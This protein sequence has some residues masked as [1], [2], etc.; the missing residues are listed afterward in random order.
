MIRSL[1]LY[2]FFIVFLGFAINCNSRDRS[3]YEVNLPSMVCMG[4]DSNTFI[5]ILPDDSM[6]LKS[7]L[8]TGLVFIPTYVNITYQ[9]QIAFNYV[10]SEWAKYINSPI[11]IRVFVDKG[12]MGSNVLASAGP[13]AYYYNFEWAKSNTL[14][15]VA[16]MEKIVGEEINGE[17]NFDIEITI[18][19]DES[20]WYFGTDGNTPP[21][22]YDFVTMVMHELAHG[23]GFNGSMQVN[24]FQQG[25]WGY[26]SGL[27][28]I[29]DIHVQ[30]GYGYNLTNTG[31]FANPSRALKNQYTSDDLYFY[32][33]LSILKNQEEGKPRLY[34]PL[35][36]NS[37][38][39]I[40]HLN[41]D[42]YPLN[43][44]NALMTHAIGTAEAI[45]IPGPLTVNI[46]EEMGWSFVKI[47]H[48][49][50]K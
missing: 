29:F 7:A 5:K 9:E 1:N 12:Y 36:Y 4:A 21:N 26:D 16:L 8:S 41:D 18:S 28:T 27:P 44:E 24:D 22:K 33:P 31:L 19:N 2:I 32:S 45:H 15:P 38:S 35:E 39:S 10:F 48:T 3:Y 42:S 20:K 11:P 34:A 47:K 14:Y 40:Y 49:Q 13:T 50:L 46:F 43:N 6:Q 17:N 25:L 37:G 30:N 23:L